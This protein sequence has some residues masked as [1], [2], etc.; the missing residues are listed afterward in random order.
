MAIAFL[1]ARS[2]LDHRPPLKFDAHSFVHERL[3][4]DSDQKARLA[5]LGSQ[6]AVR[7]T[8]I[9]MEM[10]A[11]AP[12]LPKSVGVSQIF[13]GLKVFFSSLLAIE[14][15]KPSFV[16]VSAPCMVNSEVA[17]VL[18][19][20]FS[21]SRFQALFAEAGVRKGWLAGIVDRTGTLIAR[22]EYV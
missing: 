22:S 1:A 10:C 3:D 17:F 15:A 16:Y 20:G 7:R 18:V 13:G 9:A 14:G 11:D 2:V 19:G 8:A 12:C 5:V 4:L 6:F 21:P